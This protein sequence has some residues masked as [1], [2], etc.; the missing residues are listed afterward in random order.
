MLIYKTI[1]KRDGTQPMKAAFATWNN[2]IAPVFDVARQVHIMQTESG[3]VIC[4]TRETIPDDA[5]GQKALRLM[6][7]GVETLVCG[8]VSRNLQEMISAYGI[9]VIPFVAGDL[10]QVIA[11][12]LAGDLKRERFA[13]PGCR[14]GRGLSGGWNSVKN[15]S[16]NGKNRGGMNLDLG[17]EQGRAGRRD[18][19]MG[20]GMAAGPSGFCVCPACGQEEPHKRG[21]PCFVRK[22]PKCGIALIRR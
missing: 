15:S 7:L 17:T 10:K 13:M 2:R 12:W 16:V 4:E 1:Q 8:A 6:E 14:G 21:T 9:F 18:G 3:R 19:R 5:S 22:C 20:G 11:A